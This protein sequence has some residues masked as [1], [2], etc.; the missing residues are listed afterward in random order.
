MSLVVKRNTRTICNWNDPFVE[1]HVITPLIGYICS[2]HPSIH[3][4]LHMS[5]CLSSVIK[6]SWVELNKNSWD[7]T[8][9]WWIDEL[10]LGYQEIYQVCWSFCLSLL[11]SVVITTIQLVAMPSGFRGDSWYRMASY[12]MTFLFWLWVHH[13]MCVCS[14]VS[15]VC[16]CWAVCVSLSMFACL[17]NVSMCCGLHL[18][19]VHVF[20]CVRYDCVCILSWVCWYVSV[21][22]T[23]WCLCMCV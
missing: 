20:I 9:N 10:T 19:R 22:L 23:A 5:N 7:A 4:S 17:F 14:V 1:C 11:W 8:V 16:V 13:C 2:L 21:C 3:P 18:L 6:V 15:C 12:R